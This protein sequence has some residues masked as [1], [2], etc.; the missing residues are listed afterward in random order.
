MIRFTTAGE[1]HGKGLIA[2]LEGVP[3]GLPLVADDV[4]HQLRR[5][6]AGYGRGARMTEIEA[7]AVEFVSGV[8]AGG[9][10]GSPIGMLVWNR[11][12][13]HW[14]D[15]MAPEPDDDPAAG[16]RRRVTRPRP[17]HAD[18]VGALKYDRA[19]ARDVLERASARE[20]AARVACG[21]VCRRLLAEFGVELGSHVIEIGSVRA[22]VPEA[23]P[24]PLNEAAD[25]SPVRCLDPAASDAM[26]AAVD[27]AAA[28]RETLG[29]AVEVVARGLVLGL[30]SHVSWDRRL[31][32]RIGQALLSIPAV[33]AVEIGRAVETAGRPG[34][35][36]HDEILPGGAERAGGVVRAS[37]R[38][39]GLEG[40]M[41][42]GQPVVV[43]A[44]MKPLST[45]KRPLATVDL[46][47]GKPAKAQSERSD[48]TAVPAM[49]VVAEAMLA[50]VLADAMTEQFGGDTLADVRAA[51]DAYVARLG[52]R[53]P[54][55]KR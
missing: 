32:G 37:N 27:Q 24:T 34:S 49:G 11:D 36:A 10:L 48:V 47:T 22:K 30:G 51:H 15:V 43:R 5:R 23:L 19:D 20:T 13:E 28:D 1:S 44:F 2:V 16:R 18:L 12:W 25:R 39:G 45:L 14:R 33:K 40:G 38:A 26:V 31:D 8:R 53:A 6:M 52:Q 35:E 21:A 55:R 7:D 29:G 9:T 41:T 54:G 42:T 3:A 4:D 50:I 17:G 46:D